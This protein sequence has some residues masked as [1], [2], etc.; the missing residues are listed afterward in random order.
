MIFMKIIKHGE[1]F[2]LGEI[3]CSHC[4]CEFTYNKRDI[5]IIYDK[6]DECDIEIVYCPECNYEIPIK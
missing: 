3:K 5:K 1:L 2:E 6:Q 4:K